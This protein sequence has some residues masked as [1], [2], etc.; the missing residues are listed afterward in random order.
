MPDNQTVLNEFEERKKKLAELR[1]GGWQPYPERYERSHTAADLHALAEK[2]PPRSTEEI[3]AKPEAN[4]KIAGRLMLMRPHGKLTFAK[5]R[6]HS[7][8]IQVCFMQDFLNAHA[9]AGKGP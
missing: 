5:L 2:N 9:K 7:G 8:E 6:D 3:M 1:E 4:I